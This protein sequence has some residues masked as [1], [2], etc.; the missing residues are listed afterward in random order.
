MT[1]SEV[2]MGE[3]ERVV[4]G[5]HHDPHSVL[6]AHPGPDGAVVRALRPMA[7]S[8]TLILDDGRRIPMTHLHRGVFAVTLPEDKVP[9][10]RIGVTYPGSEQETVQ[11]DPYRFLPSLGEFDLY[12]IG[13]GR[14]EELWRVLGA[15]VREMGQATGT[16]FAVWAP[17]A[18]G[19]RVAGDFNQWDGTAYPIARRGR[20]VGAVR[21]WRDRWHQVQV[22]DLRPGR[23]VAGEGRPAREPRREAARH[24]VGRVHLAV[25]LERRGLA[26]GAVRAP[27]GPRADGRLRGA[28][29]LVAAGSFLPGTGHPAR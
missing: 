10:Y 13:E 6:G 21:A 16:A 7:T 23:G 22:R 27:A 1:H 9:G 14:H 4:A 2:S 17:N 24:R 11:D 18:R 8:V 25:Q 12:L 28:P 3:I 29:R 5:H 19:I 26:Q 15:H 20:G